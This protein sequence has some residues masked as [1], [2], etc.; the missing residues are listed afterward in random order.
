MVKS[1]K[2][3][4][5]RASCCFW[6]WIHQASGAM[7][8]WQP[9]EDVA[10]RLPRPGASR[11]GAG[12]ARRAQRAPTLGAHSAGCPKDRS[13]AGNLT[14]I[15][16]G[17]FIIVYRDPKVTRNPYTKTKK[18]ARKGPSR[19]GHRKCEALWCHDGA[20]KLITGV[21]WYFDSLEMPLIVSRM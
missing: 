21:S 3:Y 19:D 13:G 11:A 16:H 18:V 2:I 8:R 20:P 1:C 17:S 12:R 4:S 15:F 10:P 14:P 6:H 9:L 5:T 7:I